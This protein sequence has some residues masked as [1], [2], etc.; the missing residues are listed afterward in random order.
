MLGIWEIRGKKQHFVYSKVLCWVCIDR[1]I[2][3]A[4]KRSFPAPKL[5]WHQ[6]RDKLMVEIMRKGYNTELRSFTQA[7]DS[8]IIDAATLILPL[9]LFLPSTDPRMQNTIRALNRSPKKG[10]LVLNSLV[11]RYNS[12]E[13]EDGFEGEQEGTFNMC[14]FWLIECLSRIGSPQRLMEARLKLEQFFT[15]GNHVYLFAEQTSSNGHH[16]GNY[17][18]A[19]THLALISS[20]F[21]LNRMLDG[22]RPQ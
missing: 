12:Q 20:T 19:F 6:T 11:Y 2:R 15:F 7:Y 10:G 18:Q 16:L 1:G 21:N 4:E 3:L 9:V 8:K 5:F 14:T 17:P 13:T 22:Y